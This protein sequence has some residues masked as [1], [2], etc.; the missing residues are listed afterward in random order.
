MYQ[1]PTM[2]LDYLMSSSQRPRMV[3]NYQSHFTDDES[4]AT[5]LVSRRTRFKSR[6]FSRAHPYHFS[7]LETE[8]S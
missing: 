6:S 4:H 7:R 2:G 3:V 1:A 5:H 8:R